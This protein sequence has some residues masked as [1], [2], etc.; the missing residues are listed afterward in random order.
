MATYEELKRQ[1]KDCDNEKPYIFISYKRNDWEEVYKKV[2]ELQKAG[3]NLWIDKE[4]SKHAGESWQKPAFDAI[5]NP[6]CKGILFFVSKSALCSPPI[7]AELSYS[8]DRM[9]TEAHGYKQLPILSYDLDNL[10][11]DHKSFADYI[12]KE[13]R[14]LYG[15]KVD[16]KALITMF[17]KEKFGNIPEDVGEKRIANELNLANAI[18]DASNLK[19]GTTT[20]ATN[21]KEIM[22]TLNANYS[23]VKNS[24]YTSNE[25][26]T[27]QG[28]TEEL[29]RKAKEEL[30]RKAKEEAERKAKEAADSK[31]A[32]VISNDKTILHDMLLSFMKSYNESKLT[33]KNAKGEEMYDLVQ[34]RLPEHIM[35]FLSNDKYFCKGSSGAGAWANCPWIAVFISEITTSTTMGVYVVYLLNAMNNELYLTLNQGTTQIVNQV[36][37][38]M[39]IDRSFVRKK[40]FAKKDDYIVHILN[41][42]SETIRK[43]IGIGSFSTEKIDSGNW[44][45]DAACI[46]SKKYTIDNLPTDTIL[47]NDLLEMLD[48]YEKYYQNHI[49]EF[50]HGNQAPD[51]KII[52]K[53]RGI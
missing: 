40:G 53:D 6:N 41:S 52:I 9:V 48:L 1:I 23:E 22:D 34:K 11:N 2:I 39:K 45:Y 15:K 30:E 10:I 32:A 42:K 27:N 3:V 47:Y 37:E 20:V 5:S 16:P 25:I 44:Q 46:L 21:I 13:V 14:E 51:K 12:Q 43:E 38:K 17:P 29:E 24:S 26:P 19:E 50:S 7:F 4:I 49:S 33:Q 8:K 31:P 36:N 35:G 18:L 28:E